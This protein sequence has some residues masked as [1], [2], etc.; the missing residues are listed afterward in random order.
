[1]RKKS[2]SHFYKGGK[3]CIN[4]NKRSLNNENELGK[5]LRV[6][7]FFLPFKK[8]NNGYSSLVR[9]ALEVI[10]NIPIVIKP[11]R[12]I[13]KRTIS[14]SIKVNHNMDSLYL[15]SFG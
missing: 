9:P 2:N 4:K 5:T 6:F 15:F 8:K 1:M 10:F 12:A 3:S 11:A 13:P 7:L 14:D